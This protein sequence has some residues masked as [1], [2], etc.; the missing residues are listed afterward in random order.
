MDWI[1]SIIGY[2]L[3]AAIGL[4][5]LGLGLVALPFVLIGAVEAFLLG[6]PVYLAV[7]FH[8]TGWL[9]AIVCWP[10]AFLLFA[11]LFGR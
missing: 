7:E 6:L 1:L 10:L 11:K 5:F 9:A 2:G 4:F 3:L 8:W